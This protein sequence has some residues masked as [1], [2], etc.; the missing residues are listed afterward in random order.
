MKK[1][2][3]ALS[4]ACAGALMAEEVSMQAIDVNASI[5]T[6]VIK[7]IHGEDVKSA[8]LAEALFKQSPSITLVR[9]SGIANDIILRGMKKD[10]INITIDGTKLCGACPNRMDPPVSHV[11]TNNIDHIEITEGPYNV[12]EFGVLSADVEVN[13]IQPTEEWHGD[14]NLGFGSWGYQKGAVSISGGTETIK[15][16]LSASSETSEQYEDGDGNNF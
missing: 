6:E 13:T 10:N 3:I 1:Q 4:L 2:F 14:V 9:R 5:D 12:E 7:D 15:V 11:L 8:D 16:L